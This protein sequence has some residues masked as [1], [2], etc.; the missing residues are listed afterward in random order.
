VGAIGRALQ[1]Y[2]GESTVVLPT[3]ESIVEP[4]VTV[5]PEVEIDTQ[6][7]QLAQDGADTSTMVDAPVELDDAGLPYD[8]RIHSNPPLRKADG[9]WKAR[10]KPADM[11]KKQW[12]D[13]IAVVEGELRQA[14]SGEP[15]VTEQQVEEEIAPPSVV[16]EEI[17][18]PSVVEEE[19][20]PPVVTEGNAPEKTFAE[21][22]KLITSNGAKMNEKLGEGQWLPTVTAAIQAHGVKSLPLLNTTRPDLIGT[23]YVE[24]EVLING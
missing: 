23:V 13:Y 6:Y 16:E 21:L 10:R 5:E 4:S 19:I 3:V 14:L 8:S 9:T 2:A 11:D 1:E 24:L 22:M 7:E 20:A 17:A 12:L 18:P 15:I